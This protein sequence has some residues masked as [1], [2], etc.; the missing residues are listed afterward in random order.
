MNTTILRHTTASIA[1]LACILIG[2]MHLPAAETITK[3]SD[4]LFVHCGPINVGVIRDGEKALLIDCGDG[5]VAGLL[6]DIGVTSVDQIVFTHHHRDQAYGVHG[7][8][9]AGSKIGV[10]EKERVYFDDVKAYWNDPKNRWR[11]YESFHPHHL[12]LAES[13]H[14]DAT[15][16][17][18]QTID[19]GPAK[20]TAIA[21]PGHTDGSIS[22]LV[23]VDNR[24][25]VFSGDVIYDAGQVWDIYSLQK[26]FSRGKR[27]IG[28]YHGFL[29]ARDELLQ[30]L[31]RLKSVK[32]DMLVP[33]HGRII[34]DP[35]QGIDLLIDRLEKCYDNYVAISALRHYFPEL[36]EEYA[37]RPDHMK[38]RP[39]KT[40]PSC[41]RHFGTTW[42]VISKDKAAFVM[43][44][45]GTGPINEIQ[46]LIK[47]GEITGVEG[48]WVT[49]YHFDHT[50]GIPKFQTTF[51]CLCYADKRLARVL[52]NPLAWR[53]P[54]ISP[55]V[56]RVDNATT[57]GQS[58]QW[59]EFRMTAYYLPGQT[60][61][62]GALLIEK[63]DLKMLFVGDSFTPAG[64][65]DYCANNRNWLGHRVGFD[66]C[67]EL[68]ERLKP[69]HIFNCHVADAFDF[70]PVQCRK[71]RANLASREKLL[72][73][74]VPW[75]HANHGTDESWVRCFPYE[76]K[77]SAGK[78]IKLDVVV[79][80]H[81]TKANMTACRAVLPSAWR[82]K[83][84]P[85]IEKS[86]PPKSEG[87]LSISFNIPAT[88]KPG[89]YAIPIDVRYAG[90]QLPQFTEA[91]IV[92]E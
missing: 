78:A 4:H 36:F 54:C 24:R 17:D 27:R 26:G 5:C 28:D 38:I 1:A 31:R 53:L 48:L 91:I 51:D 69:T 11:V 55:G 16:T 77:T 88:A 80:N 89:R 73:Q 52:T 67:V 46:K 86:I 43:D 18:G 9:A 30:S 21:T 13:V 19:W 14:V 47:K 8:V 7:L 63:D 15:Y 90:R 85:W 72:G 33:S 76:Q 70:T 39:G 59:R 50:D 68:I 82:S 37:N 20:I 3:L 66:R 81:S 58:W 64:V 2:S 25:V 71:M 45:G 49:H 10:P 23:E 84:A 75:D 56:T 87:R 74:L 62:H 35:P 65:D 57:D 42:L 92:V 34:D 12:M 40:P 22:Y 79:T 41:L 29:G 61:Y 6:S 32:P 44:C 60:L 83:P